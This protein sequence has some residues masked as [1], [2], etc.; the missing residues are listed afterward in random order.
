MNKEKHAQ[1]V[2]D[3]VCILWTD[4]FKPEHFDEIDG[5]H[6]TLRKTAKQASVVKQTVSVEE[7]E[8]LVEMVKSVSDIFLETKK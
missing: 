5:L 2:K 3:E 7:A 4:Y 8:R 6:D 1:K